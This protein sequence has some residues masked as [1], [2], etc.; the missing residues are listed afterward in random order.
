M[1]PR[2]KRQKEIFDYIKQ[3]IER[4]GYQPSYQQIARHL[5]ISS[6]G[7]IAKHIAALEKQGLLERSYDNGS[8]K[9]EINPTKSVLEVVCQIEWLE[10]PVNENYAENWERNFLY[11]PRFLIGQNEP[12][13]I[14]AFRVRND[15]MLEQH[16]LEGDVVLIKKSSFARDRD[17]VVALLENKRAV[18]KKY[19]RLGADIE[20]R[21][22][23]ENFDSIIVPA[24]QIEIKGILQAIL[25]PA[26]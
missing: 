26:I 6:K 7:G 18:L 19:Y 20:L 24:D 10:L 9:L 11:V 4:H 1:Q 23:N 12:D 17:I 5:N 15:S 14:R 13:E 16:I 25:R 8:F 21:P 22:A 3:Y 2:T